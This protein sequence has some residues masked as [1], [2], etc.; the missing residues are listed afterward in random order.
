MTFLTRLVKQNCHSC[1][2]TERAFIL[3][4]RFPVIPNAT[5]LINSVV[6]AKEMV[7]LCLL[8]WKQKWP[9]SGF[10]AG[11]DICFQR[12]FQPLSQS[13]SKCFLCLRKDIFPTANVWWWWWCTCSGWKRKT[14]KGQARGDAL[15]SF[16]YRENKSIAAF[17][18]L[19]KKNCERFT[20]H[21][22]S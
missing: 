1:S 15:W 8:C 20:N 18:Y 17:T 4:Q 10:S 6:G 19:W 7:V 2:A 21:I 5:P 11:E 22:D 12:Y 14:S 13:T 3:S 16:N 9:V